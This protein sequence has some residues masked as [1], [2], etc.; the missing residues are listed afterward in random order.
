VADAAPLIFRR[1]KIAVPLHPVVKQ[2]LVLQKIDAKIAKVAKKLARLPVETQQRKSSIDKQQQQRDL[3]KHALQEAEV[4]TSALERRVLEIEQ[5][6]EKQIQYRDKAANAAIFA[7]AEHQIDYLRKDK[8]ELQN[9]Q[10]RFM[11]KVE[12]LRPQ[13]QEAEE[14]LA[15]LRAEFEEFEAEA[16]KLR[17]E[18]EAQKAEVAEDRAA[19]LEGVNRNELQM[20]D[21]IF[22]M[23]DGEAVVAAHGDICTGC[24]TRITPNDAAVLAS[25]SRIVTCKACGRILYAQ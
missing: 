20:Y 11:E 6:V 8:D 14:R 21:D 3:L 19:A 13:L 22:R 15:K 25:G 5:N 9:E 17:A 2:L 24:F 18:L 23:R 16:D 12:Q 10:F 4:E 7:A 1:R